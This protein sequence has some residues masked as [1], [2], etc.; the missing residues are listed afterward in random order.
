MQEAITIWGKLLLATGGALKPIKCFFH[1]IS[2]AWKE[3][4][5]WFYENNEEDEEFQ[6]KV[7]LVDGSFGDILTRFIP[8]EGSDAWPEEGR[9]S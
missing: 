7:P 8:R 5:S 9:D 3:D 2:F 4:G 1:L 6:A